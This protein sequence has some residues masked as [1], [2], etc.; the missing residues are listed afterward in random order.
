MIDNIKSTFLH[1]KLYLI[2]AYLT[3]EVSRRKTKNNR[4]YYFFLIEID[5]LVLNP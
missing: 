2:S 5:V 4:E 1:G 3:Q